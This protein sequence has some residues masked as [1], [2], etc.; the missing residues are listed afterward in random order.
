MLERWGYEE[1]AGVR[2]VCLDKETNFR[3]LFATRPFCKG[4]RVFEFKGDRKPT[5]EATAYALQIS[6]R[7]SFESLNRVIFDNFLNHQCQ[8]NCRVIFD[9]AQVW[10]EAAIDILAG[11]ELGFHYDTTEHDFRGH[12][13]FICRCGSREC[14]GPIEGFR[15]LS[16]RQQRK[17]FHDLLP[18]LRAKFLLNKNHPGR[19]LQKRLTQKKKP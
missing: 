2:V 7:T 4:E 5:S 17:L 19:E 10:L 16:R 15:Y 12:G 13:S 11:E 18:Y 14:L 8:P 6:N 9:G 1:P 3:G